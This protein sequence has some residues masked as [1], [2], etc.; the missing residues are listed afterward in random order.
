MMRKFGAAVLAA[1][2]SFTPA[3]AADC[4]R[5]MTTGGTAQQLQ[6]TGTSTPI[7]SVRNLLLMN[8]SANL[9]CVAF[10]GATAAIAGTNCEAGSFTLQ[11]GSNTASG[12]S[13]SKPEFMTISSVSIV[14]S[15]T[16]D[17]YSCDFTR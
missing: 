8:N 11:P 3:I 15:G 5:T 2:L 12:G 6:V 9:M 16:G 1:F 4:S 14:S 17:R 13:F 7:G 10:N